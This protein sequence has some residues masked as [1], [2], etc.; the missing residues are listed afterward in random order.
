MPRWASLWRSFILS[1]SISVTQIQE[2]RQNHWDPTAFERHTIR[3]H[4]DWFVSQPQIIC[5]RHCQNTKK[6]IFS[7]IDWSEPEFFFHRLF[8]FNNS[9]LGGR[10]KRYFIYFPDTIILFYRQYKSQLLQVGMKWEF[11]IFSKCMLFCEWIIHAC[12]FFLWL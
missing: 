12:F 10:K 1:L 7:W 2:K 9:L 3:W 4:W 8:S 5:A 11:T 6:V